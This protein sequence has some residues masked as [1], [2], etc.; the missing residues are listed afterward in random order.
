MLPILP[1]II[2]LGIVALVA[3][4]LTTGRSPGGNVDA[5]RKLT[6][7]AIIAV[8]VQAIHFGEELSTGFHVQFPA[9]FGL[10]PMPLGFFVAFNVG[11]LVIWAITIPGLARSSRLAFF[12]FWF[13]GLAS[14]MN[15]V[16]HPLMALA[17]SGYFPGLIT[18][19]LCGIAG[20]MLVAWLNRSTATK[21]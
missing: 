18:S 5:F 14:V 2:L 15:A 6:V 17:V 19:P 4:R 10:D 8:V 16:A 12:V 20:G 1:S 21:G 7:F 11:W 13:L 9:L 3:L